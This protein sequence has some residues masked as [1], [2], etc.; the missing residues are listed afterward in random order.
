MKDKN[1]KEVHVFDKVKND[2]GTVFEITFIPEEPSE[3]AKEWLS[4]CELVE[5]SIESDKLLR[6]GNISLIQEYLACGR[7]EESHHFTEKTVNK[8]LTLGTGELKNDR[9]RTD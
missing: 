6:I 3:K 7:N 4:R 8:P 1:G 2:I 9:L 5:K